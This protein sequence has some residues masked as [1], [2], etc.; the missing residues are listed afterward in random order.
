ME[1]SCL[2]YGDYMIKY[3]D[4]EDSLFHLFAVVS[5]SIRDL[6]IEDRNEFSSFNL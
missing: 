1:S 4:I 6:L 2:I 3:A 5:V